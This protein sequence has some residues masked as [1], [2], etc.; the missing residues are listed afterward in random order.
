MIT[1]FGIFS[2]RGKT[3]KEEKKYR[4]AFDYDSWRFNAKGCEKMALPECHVR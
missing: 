2:L 1:K 3:E 4:E